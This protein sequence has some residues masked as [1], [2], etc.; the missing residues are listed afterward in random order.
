M[1]EFYNKQLTM[2]VVVLLLDF[3]EQEIAHQKL[4]TKKGRS[5]EST[6]GNIEME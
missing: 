5:N 1:R 2:N 3:W 6:C 4:K